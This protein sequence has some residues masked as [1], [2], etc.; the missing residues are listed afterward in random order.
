MREDS[1]PAPI[2]IGVIGLGPSGLSVLERASEKGLSHIGFDQA[3]PAQ[4]IREFARGKPLTAAP[5]DQSLRSGLPLPN[6][7]T[8]PEPLLGEWSEHVAKSRLHTKSRPTVRKVVAR[9]THFEIHYG[10]S[11]FICCKHVVIAIAQGAPRELNVPGADQ[12]IVRYSLDDPALFE[13]QCV[14]VVG[15]GTAA[16]ENALQLHQH[17]ARVHILTRGPG[18]DK[19]NPAVA[20]QIREAIAR[21]LIWHFPDAKIERVNPGGIEFRSLEGQ[22]HLPCECVL[23]RLGF[24]EP[25]EFLSVACCLPENPPLSGVGEVQAV[26]GL[27]IVGPLAGRSLIWQV[28]EQGYEVVERILGNSV[29]PAHIQRLVSKLTAA[30]LSPAIPQLAEAFQEH[31]I[32]LVRLYDIFS[33]CQ[34]R[35]VRPGEVVVRRGDYPIGLYILAS[36]RLETRGGRPASA[37]PGTI[38]CAEEFFA[39]PKRRY[40]AELR[41][42]E[43]SVVLT[44]EEGQFMR[45]PDTL[46]IPLVGAIRYRHAPP[47]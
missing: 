3:D 27:F 6:G 41:A 18:F 23:A 33:R 40:E 14:A 35:R 46:K 11:D 16:A 15:G 8:T 28:I 24:H 36:G 17:G 29:Q 12:R 32:E 2:A 25:R 5:A 47:V 20:T 42:A 13:G 43:V 1:S 44:L 19:A 39:R 45:M 21:K 31:D 9:P 38:F 7:M 34:I 26:P 22:G 37:R 10:Q 30:G 4:T